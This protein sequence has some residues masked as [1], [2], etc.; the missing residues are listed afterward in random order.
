KFT[1]FPPLPSVVR[2]T[3]LYF[4]LACHAALDAASRLCFSG[5]LLEFIPMKIGAGMTIIVKGFMGQYTG[6]V[7]YY[8]L[9]VIRCH[10]YFGPMREGR[11]NFSSGPHVV[12]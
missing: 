3:L 2:P 4:W 8:M 9:W 6:E 5:F 12:K 11:M 10:S 1:S 7:N